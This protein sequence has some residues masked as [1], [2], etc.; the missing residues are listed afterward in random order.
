[1]KTKYK[2]ILF[3]GCLAVT[4]LGS[5]KDS[6]LDQAPATGISTDIALNTEADLKSAVLG[7][8]AGMRGVDLYGRTVPVIG[9]VL[10]DNAFIASNNSGRYTSF[11][12]YINTKNDGNIAGIWNTA[13]LVI[14]R[15]NRVINSTP[16][17]GT[18][19]N[20][21]QY[22]GEAYAGR[23]LMYFELLRNFSNINDL[24]S[25]GVP[26]VLD[27]DYSALPA[28]N[29]VGEV[30]TQ[31]ESDLAQG[32]QLMTQFSTTA[33]MSKYTARALQAKVALYKKDYANALTYAN[34]VINN[35]GFSLLTSAGFKAYWASPAPQSAK[36][37]TLFEVNSDAISNLAFDALSNMYVQPP[38]GYGDVLCANA[39]YND[40]SSTDVRKT[41]LLVGVRGTANPA[42]IVNKFP[43]VGN[44][45]D[46]TKIIRLSEVY[47]IAAEAAN[48]TGNDIMA[49]TMLNTLVAQ[50][51]PAQVYVS[52]GAQ[53]LSDIQDERRKE[54][55]FEGDRFYNL[56]R[57]GLD[58]TGRTHA[59]NSV[60]I[61]SYRRIMPIPQSEMD[62]NPNMVQNT[63]W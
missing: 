26:I 29:T 12:K 28:R 20:I 57:L 38:G 42:Y 62:V 18:Q 4:L 54:L 6:F 27:F 59:P 53:L 48:R 56:N 60:A 35:S 36:V 17:S 52:T 21:D 7:M 47:L 10:S 2:V 31:I 51:D 11:D 39:L 32:Y 50:R 3:S 15:A 58:I 41:L 55:A 14:G 63:G 25:P 5:C 34:D 61:S 45:K 22:K 33:R 1:M 8:Y 16:K 23:A 30:F 24:N 46:D 43:N 13:Y 9:E 44:D 37:E 49:L 19:A 40:Y